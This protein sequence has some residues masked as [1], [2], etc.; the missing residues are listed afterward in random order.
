[1]PLPDSEPENYSI[2]DMMDRLRSRGDGAKD[3]S[4]QLVTREDG[5]QAYKVRKRK[6]RS[7]QPKKAKEQRKRGYRVAL[8]VLA[9]GLLVLTGLGILGGFLY[10]NSSA[11]RDQV[12]GRIRTWTG[13]E[14]KLTELGVTPVSASATILELKW[15]ENSILDHLRLSGIKGD[16]MWS[17]LLSGKWKGTE[18]L[19]HNG[20]TL[21][22]RPGTLSNS[23][24]VTPAEPCPFQFR[25]RSNKFTVLMGDPAKPLFRLKD[26]EASLVTLDPN[27]GIA[28]LQFEGGNL[29]T[30]IWGNFRLNFAS[31]QFEGGVMRLGSLR[32]SPPGGG[33]AELSISNPSDVALD[34]KGE[35]TQLVLKLERM[36]LADLLGPSVGS[37]FA[38]TVETPEDEAPGTL[39]FRSATK[40]GLALRVPFKAVAG[41]ETSFTNLP[42]FVTLSSHLK[43]TWYQQPRFEVTRGEG[44]K[45]GERAGI[46][47]L[48]LEARGRLAI[49]GR[50]TVN[51]EGI[52][53]GTLE[54]GL[55]SSAVA[56][57]SPQL[58]SLFV[59]QANGFLWATVTV[60]GTSRYPA[61]NMESLLAAAAPASPAKGGAEALEDVFRELTTPEGK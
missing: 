12:T 28:N 49:T 19:S 8:I 3:D 51:P 24:P 42:M 35:G 7:Q 54:V 60:S 59:R 16:L 6:R 20:G 32:L 27:A 30:A 5:S 34:F 38:A 26:S 39:L 25:Y 23:K 21:L 31:L 43:D 13:A 47:N 56:A 58:R 17:S 36:P 15:P 33:K 45:D 53:T 55:P 4:A 50:M 61:D 37:W 9:V 10:L 52:L 14:P 22:L 29:D 57:S 40:S 46:E 1:M 41:T 44:V 11:Y 2:D 48:N 18:L